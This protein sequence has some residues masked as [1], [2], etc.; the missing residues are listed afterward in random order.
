MSKQDRQGVRTAA[1]L[2]RKYNFSGLQKAVAIAEDEIVKINK[3]QED[4]VNATLRQFGEVKGKLDNVAEQHFGNGTPT[5]DTPPAAEWTLDQYESHAGDLYYDRDTGYSYRF[6][7]GEDEFDW[8][9]VKDRD[10]IEALALANVAKD[11][12]DGKRRVFVA[13]PAP[14]YDVGD[15]WLKDKELYV[16]QISKQE[17]S[18]AAADF[19][20]ATKYTDDSAVFEL[21]QE[22]KEN[23]VTNSDIQTIITKNNE[24]ILS[25]VSAKYTTI[26]T[27]TGLIKKV[28]SIETKANQAADHFEW[29]VKSDKSATEFTLTDRMV[30][31]VTESLV[32]T[33]GSGSTIISGGKIDADKIFAQDIT[34]TGKITGL[35]G[36]FTG[37]IYADAGSIG[38]LELKDGYLATT[39]YL[40]DIEQD[41]IAYYEVMPGIENG[42]TSISD[43]SKFL[44]IFYGIMHAGGLKEELYHVD[45]Y[46][47]T[48]TQSLTLPAEGFSEKNGVRFT[49]YDDATDDYCAIMVLDYKSGV[50][51]GY[52]DYIQDRGTTR[53]YG[54]AIELHTKESV[55]L[56]CDLAL[57]VSKCMYC[58]QSDGSLYS[59]LSID[60]NSDLALGYDLHRNAAGKTYICGDT[61]GFRSNKTMTADNNLELQYSK[62]IYGKDREGNSLG[63]LRMGG[64]AGNPICLVGDGLY[65]NKVGRTN[66]NGGDSV[67]LFCANNSVTLINYNSSENYNAFFYPGDGKICLGTASNKW[68]AVFSAN[69]TIQTSDEREKE[70]IVPMGISTAMDGATCSDV[71]SEL[72]DR[73]NPV[74][75]NFIGGNGKICYGFVAQHIAVAMEELGIQEDDLD[76][77]HHDYWT[78]PDTGEAKDSYGLAYANLIALLVHEVQKLKMLINN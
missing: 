20:P 51:I 16:C 43:D 13:E 63:M 72:F 31:L 36:D 9:L 56:D 14:P 53:I 11:T 38:N 75:Y 46:G 39:I 25:Q 4:F 15:L 5:L 22:I 17:G 65:N 2:E 68:Y 70:N 3:T 69:A 78:D 37:T 23:Y 76:L 50:R 66:V 55:Y 54:E 41:A 1:D 6:E 59:V 18:Y 62:G 58:K 32:I 52:D 47:N 30:K 64:T 27:V 77:V 74:Q 29:I 48:L 8:I 12:A 24:G 10:V 45:A 42:A 7:K 71:Y 67:S 40:P 35:N 60:E 21:E 57:P 61:V 19:V 26:D 33:D 49:Q 73:L 28:E 34:A 44:R